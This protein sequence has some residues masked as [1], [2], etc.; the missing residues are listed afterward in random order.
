MRLCIEPAYCFG[1][2]MQDLTPEELLK[3]GKTY[4]YPDALY[5]QR[6]HIL[7]QHCNRA[8]EHSQVKQLDGA[9]K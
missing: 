5:T 9:A 3:T 2:D 8:A 6:Q 7:L 4:E 1:R